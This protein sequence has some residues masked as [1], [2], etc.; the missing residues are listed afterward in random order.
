MVTVDCWLFK[1]LDMYFLV[2]LA[3]PGLSCGMWDLGVKSEPPALG[4]LSLSPWVTRKV[5]VSC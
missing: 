4:A 3:A 5:P 2:H 1:F